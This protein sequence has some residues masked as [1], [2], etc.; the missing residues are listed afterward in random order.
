LSEQIRLLL[1]DD[2][3]LFREGVS[4]L[5]ASEAD[6]NV[7]A[8]TSDISSALDC[9]R[10]ETIDV[11]LL[12]FDLGSDRAL[13]FVTEGRAISPC[14]KVLVVTAGVDDTSAMELI[15]AGVSG[16]F[17][18]HNDPHTLSKRIR[19]AVRGEVFLEETY[20]KP[21]FKAAA[22][23]ESG[24]P[25]LTDRERS[26]LTYLLEGHPN[27]VIADRLGSS[28]SAIKGTIQQL[29]QKTGVRTRSQLVRVALE[30]FKAELEADGR[31]NG[32]SKLARSD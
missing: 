31:E 29:F 19:G 30:Q 9:L 23:T 12:D 11:A 3:A 8:V 27:K 5:L 7:V 1:I 13:D 28:E 18:K 2:H 32:R 15:Q 10:R 25:L 6:L 21:L 20:L 14:M 24:R 16:I 22:Q 26:V 4:R 17:H